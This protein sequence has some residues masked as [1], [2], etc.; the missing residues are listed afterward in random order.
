MQVLRGSFDVIEAVI[1]CVL[2]SLS[3]D[4]PKLE[5]ILSGSLMNQEDVMSRG[6]SWEGL[7]GFLLYA[8][9]ATARAHAAGQGGVGAPTGQ[10]FLKKTAALP[11]SRWD[12]GLLL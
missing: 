4:L 8:Q 5:C 6:S 10:G 1:T 3:R 11:G 12:L 7:L 2:R 9:H